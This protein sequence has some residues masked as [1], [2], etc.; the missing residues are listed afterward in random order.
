MP[1]ISVFNSLGKEVEKIELDQNLF[2]GKVNKALLS[3]IILM[4]QAN[5][6]KGLAATKTRGQVRGGGK[7]P[8]KQKGTGRAR[9]GSIRSPL[10]RGGGIV[11]GPH[12]RDYSYEVPKKAR[13]LSVLNAI[14]AK[15]IEREIFVVDSIT[16]PSNKTK[17]FANILSNISKIVHGL[18]D[19]DNPS[20]PKEKKIKKVER[21]LF[22]YEKPV[23]DLILASRNMKNVSTV[24]VNNMNS[25]DILLSDHIIF[26]K[27]ALENFVKT[28]K[29]K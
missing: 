18:K 29:L 20:Q 16:L 1:E 5:K 14:N 23:R 11:F 13:N 7:K 8:W 21:F 9:A 10:W 17:E 22:V 3:E 25:L 27:P 26:S 15:L 12:P 24:L 2:S 6:R 4:H 19:S 28:V